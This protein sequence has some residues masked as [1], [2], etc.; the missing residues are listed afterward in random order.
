MM[1][2]RAGATKVTACE[3]RLILHALRILKN[4]EFFVERHF[5]CISG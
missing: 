2:A 1:A 3:V 4:A 5:T